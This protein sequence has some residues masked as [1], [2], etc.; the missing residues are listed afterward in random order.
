MQFER[1]VEAVK[2]PV[3]TL[4]E[5]WVESGFRILVWPSGYAS[6]MGVSDEGCCPLDESTSSRDTQA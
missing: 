5:R 2:T 4:E 3:P 6:T 1:V